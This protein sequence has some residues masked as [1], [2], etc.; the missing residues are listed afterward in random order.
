MTSDSSWQNSLILSPAGKPKPILANAILAIRNAP[1]WSGVLGFDQFAHRTVACRPPPWAAG[2]NDWRE[3]SWTDHDDVEATDWLQ[4]RDIIVGVDTAQKAVENASLQNAF[5][6]IVDYLDRLRWDGRR[7]LQFWLERYLGAEAS[8]YTA[9]VGRCALIAAV[10]RIR[11]PGCKMDTVP[12][13]E[14]VQGTGKSSALRILGGE[15]FTDEIAEFGSKDA[16]MQAASAW[17][18]EIA[19]LDAMSKPE[20]SRIKAFISRSTDRFRPPFGRRIIESKRQSV[21]WG[22]TN[23]ENYLKDETGARRFW[24]FRAGRIDLEALARDR[25]QL[26]AEACH[27]FENGT[28][29][30]LKG[31]IE[32]EAAAE[33]RD[34]YAAD[35]WTDAIN[36]FVADREDVSINEILHN[37]FNLSLENVSQRDQ[38]R[39]AICLRQHGFERFKKRVSG[40]FEWRYR[41]PFPL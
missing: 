12:I 31:D 33:Q 29:W 15:W 40:N 35:P 26:F 30:W 3:R 4:H 14:G 24:P 39:V 8:N 17:F 36:I 18:I 16:A 41:R 27:L 22:T 11:R 38:N 2:C 6:P 21:F 5:H 20:T 9:E 28:P 37:V 34:R 25:D 23:G 7:R 32:V 1:E 10:A 19:E 13:I